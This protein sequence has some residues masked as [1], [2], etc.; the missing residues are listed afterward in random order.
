MASSST[1]DIGNLELSSQA[2]DLAIRHTQLQALAETIELMI[3]EIATSQHVEEDLLTIQQ[4]LNKFQHLV[5]EADVD[6]KNI[7]E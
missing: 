1:T 5:E 6:L 7:G 4:Q 2:D 3:K